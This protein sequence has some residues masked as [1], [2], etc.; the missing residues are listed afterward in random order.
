MRSV[1]KLIHTDS[2]PSTCADQKLRQRADAIAQWFQGP[3]NTGHAVLD[4]RSVNNDM[5]P[6][7][8]AITMSRG[9]VLPCS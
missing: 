1:D 4:N 7:S 3:A 8:S 9:L 6:F 2:L 5:P